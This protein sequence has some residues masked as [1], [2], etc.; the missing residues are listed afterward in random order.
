M[1][2]HLSGTTCE[3]DCTASYQAGTELLLT[4]AP[5]VGWYLRSWEGCVASHGTSCGVKLLGDTT[6]TATFAPTGD[7][8]G[9][10]SEMGKG[11]AR[12][13]EL[14]RPTKVD[15]PDLPAS[16]VYAVPVS[17]SMLHASRASV[18]SRM[19]KPGGQIW[20]PITIE[21][22]RQAGETLRSAADTIGTLAH[23]PGSQRIRDTLISLGDSFGAIADHPLSIERV[24]AELQQVSAD[25][26]S[27]SSTLAA[28]SQEFAKLGEAPAVVA[29][30]EQA[31]QSIMVTA[32]LIARDAPG[33][34]LAEM[35]DPGG[36]LP[37]LG[38]AFSEAGEAL[39]DAAEVALGIGVL[40]FDECKCGA[41]RDM[42]DKPF[43]LRAL[44]D[45]DAL[46]ERFKDP[47]D[48]QYY[49]R[50]VEASC[51]TCD[52][53]VREKAKEQEL[54]YGFVSM[55]TGEIIVI[56]PESAEEK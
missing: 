30:L 23:T 51:D 37:G 28:E 46:K 19:A 10:M 26:M 27:L 32:V 8:L 29:S 38:A 18:A 5:E 44:T 25:V 42:N 33:L 13:G 24:R 15:V 20:L 3:R 7:L 39:Q 50:V 6:I 53:G 52:W 16:L 22:V 48:Y 2:D 17:A 41:T 36:A 35:L 34:D 12:A 47:D 4:A 9:A 55:L 49:C 11:L 40:W 31:S 54:V 1:T 45:V 14:L 21:A 43:V 56:E